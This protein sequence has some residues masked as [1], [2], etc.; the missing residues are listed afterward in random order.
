[1]K[2]REKHSSTR[3]ACFEIWTCTVNVANLTMSQSLEGSRVTVGSRNDVTY[4]N[5]VPQGHQFSCLLMSSFLRCIQLNWSLTD[6]FR[7]RF[8]I[9][10][11]R[12]FA[13]AFSWSSIYLLCPVNWHILG[14]QPFQWIIQISRDKTRYGRYYSFPDRRAPRGKQ[15]GCWQFG[16]CI[17]HR[18]RWH[19]FDLLTF[20]RNI[21]TITS[22]REVSFCLHLLIFG[23]HIK[24][25]GVYLWHQS[26]KNLASL[27]C[28]RITW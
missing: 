14:P 10:Q 2:R 4:G 11:R 26:R 5:S 9:N 3:K 17:V 22:K 12:L 16:K 24:S 18:L 8:G 20:H 13:L 23:V 27:V 15:W 1:M 21:W 28:S 25:E 19:V 7:S 6:C